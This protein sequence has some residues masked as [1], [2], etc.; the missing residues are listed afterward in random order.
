MK[1]R[2]QGRE[3]PHG[4]RILSNPSYISEL[5]ARHDQRLTGIDAGVDQLGMAQLDVL[6]DLFTQFVVEAAAARHRAPATDQFEKSSH[7]EA[8]VP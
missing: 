5:P 2:I 8:T 7:G 4:A 1:N 3:A 6:F